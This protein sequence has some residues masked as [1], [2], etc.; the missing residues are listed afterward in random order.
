MIMWNDQL[1]KY[2][3]AEDGITPHR[4]KEQVD[5]YKKGIG[6]TELKKAQDAEDNTVNTIDTVPAMLSE[7]LR[8]NQ[9]ILAKIT[10]IE[11]ILH[12]TEHKRLNLNLDEPIFEKQ[13]KE[14]PTI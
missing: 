4:C 7:V 14:V 5:F 12:I 11:N 2:V 6:L 10:K 9:K 3:L 8:S 13:V 1:K